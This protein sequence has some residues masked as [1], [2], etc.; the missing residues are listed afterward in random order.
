MSSHAS[1]EMERSSASSGHGAHG[2]PHGGSHEEPHEGAPEWLISF[3]DNV[4]LMMGFFVI[5]LAMNMGPK[6]GGGESETP[7]EGEAGG[8]PL[9][10]YDTAIAI[11]E[12]FHNP[13]QLN[14][15]DPNEQALV[16][17]LN[18]RRGLGISEQAGPEG[19]EHNV[20]SLLRGQFQGLCGRV[21]FEHLS[22]HLGEEGRKAV[23]AIGLH[24]RG[25]RVMIDIRGH[26]SAAEAYEDPSHGM[27]LAYDRAWAVAEALGAE[28]L[29][30]RQFRVTACADNE[31]IDA[32]VY[33]E[34][35]HQRN[36]RV[37]IVVTDDVMPE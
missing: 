35:G 25:L 32:Q 27:K 6:G 9:N 3:A 24:V 30:W 21:T 18:E 28:G 20:Q 17:H 13:V 2:P 15:M 5:M 11:R 23:S 4:T 16:R 7:L 33:D 22:D 12:A 37:E 31:R 1:H 26:V 10:F 8:P 14:S 36:E 34:F 29:S 19:D